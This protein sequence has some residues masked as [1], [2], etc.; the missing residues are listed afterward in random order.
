MLAALAVSLIRSEEIAEEQ[1][2]DV[3]RQTGMAAARIEDRLVAMVNTVMGTELIPRRARRDSTPATL[4]D[5]VKSLRRAVPISRLL[6]LE[7]ELRPYMAAIIVDAINQGGDALVI[8]E[9]TKLKELSAE[10]FEN[11]KLGLAGASYEPYHLL[12]TKRHVEASKRAPT[13]EQ[14]RDMLS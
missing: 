2:D 13:K 6:E 9:G 1:G 11:Y 10:E 14:V 12:T 4:F 8:P 7:D 3:S 5:V